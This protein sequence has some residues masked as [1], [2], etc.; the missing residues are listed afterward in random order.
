MKALDTNVLARLLLQDDAAQFKRAKALLGSGQVFTAP[1]TVMLELVW[2][3]ESNDCSSAEIAH[4]LC[5]LL[6]LPN[7]RLAQADTVR[8]ALGAYVWPP[9][10]TCRD[11]AGLEILMGF[12]LQA[13]FSQPI[14][15]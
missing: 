2:V 7:F 6:D 14:Q 1:V 4:A 10:P 11:L 13:P 8:A 5:M 15:V 12:W 3:L 9:E